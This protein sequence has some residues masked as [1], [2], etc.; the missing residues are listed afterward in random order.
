MAYIANK[1]VRFDRNYAVG[2]VIPDAVID[3]KMTRKL[4]EMGRILCVD[5]RDKAETGEPQQD[6]PQDGAESEGKSD[7]DPGAGG[8]FVCP[9]CGKA[10]GSKNALSAHSRTHKE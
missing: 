1:P 6:D 9:D 5:I 8:E 10:F 3:P 7:P 2:E 4:V